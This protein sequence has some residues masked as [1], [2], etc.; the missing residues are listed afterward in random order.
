MS[1]EMP[2]AD[3]Q[4]GKLA[5]YSVCRRFMGLPRRELPPAL[6]A[7]GKGNQDAIQA[8]MRGRTS[9]FHSFPTLSRMNFLYM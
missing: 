1:G 3:A 8:R 5:E 9:L 2:A 6:T 7:G 4:G